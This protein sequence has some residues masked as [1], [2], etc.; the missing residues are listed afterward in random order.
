MLK[1]IKRFLAWFWSLFFYE[2]HLYLS[3]NGD[4]FYK[5]IT[6]M[7]ITLKANQQ[8]SQTVAYVDSRGNPVTPG[9]APAWASSDPTIV[10]VVAAADGL[11]AVASAAGKLGTATVTVTFSNATPATEDF[12]VVAGDPATATIT[13]TVPVNEPAA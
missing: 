7:A 2:G 1:L 10:A 4:N 9:G 13:S 8:V 11:S 6:H 5:G 3:F 12:T